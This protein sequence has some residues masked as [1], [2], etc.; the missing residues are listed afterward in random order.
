MFILDG[1]DHVSVLFFSCTSSLSV[2][3]ITDMSPM[4]AII[5]IS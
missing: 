2:F 3:V 1:K 4:M 5:F